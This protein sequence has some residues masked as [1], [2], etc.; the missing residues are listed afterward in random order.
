MVVVVGGLVDYGRMTSSGIAWAADDGVGCGC[1]GGARLIR[2]GC[3]C[4]EVLLDSAG[5]SRRVR[6]EGLME[7]ERGQARVVME[8]TTRI[9][10]T[11]DDGG[12]RRPSTDDGKRH[13]R[14]NCQHVMEYSYE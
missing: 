14:D 6:L 1:G 2:S 7:L 9:E 12:E 11:E 4:R 10:G 3:S 5:T 8:K 13:R